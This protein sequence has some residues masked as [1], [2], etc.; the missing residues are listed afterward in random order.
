MFCLKLGARKPTDSPVS[1]LLL[2]TLTFLDFNLHSHLNLLL[3]RWVHDSLKDD[4]L[5]FPRGVLERAKQ[6]ALAAGGGG[7]IYLF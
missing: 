2:S 7:L 4:P 5:L 6:G 3:S 1:V